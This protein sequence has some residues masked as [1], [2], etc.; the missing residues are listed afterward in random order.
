MRCLPTV[1]KLYGGNVN[2]GLN[3]N[4]VFPIGNGLFCMVCLIE[5][6]KCIKLTHRISSMYI[7]PSAVTKHD[8]AAK[9]V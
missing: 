3:G 7:M 2:M 9:F 8:T 6:W 1:R 5:R 4:K